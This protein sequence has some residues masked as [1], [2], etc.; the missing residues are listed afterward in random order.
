M[1]VTY[2]IQ[3]H[4]PDFTLN[5]TGE[6]FKDGSMFDVEHFPRIEEARTAINEHNTK[7]CLPGSWFTITEEKFEE[8]TEDVEKRVV[9]RIA[10]IS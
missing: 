3:F 10:A 7:D 1:I 9:E 6:K 5:F 8:V 2:T 4:A